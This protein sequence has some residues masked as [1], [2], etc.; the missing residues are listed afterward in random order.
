MNIVSV[1]TAPGACTLGKV[2]PGTS[3]QIGNGTCGSFGCHYE[4]TSPQSFGA[5]LNDNKG[6]VF[7]TWWQESGIQMYFFPRGSTPEDLLDGNS[8]DPASWTSPS[9]V[10]NSSVACNATRAFINQTIIFSMPLCGTYAGF[11][12]TYR[13]SGCPG[14]CTGLIANASNWNECILGSQLCENL[15]SVMPRVMEWR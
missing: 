3:K 13:A 12:S 11:S 7:A 2:D 14:N 1:Y 4:D 8:P 6:G 9:V 10:I 5:G 15:Q